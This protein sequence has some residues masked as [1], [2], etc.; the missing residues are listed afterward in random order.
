MQTLEAPVY[1]IAGITVLRDH[2]SDSDF[3][4][5][6]GP[7]HITRD[8]GEPVFSMLTYRNAVGGVN[9]NPVTRDQLGGAFLMFEVDCGLTQAQLTT[10]EGELEALVPP[11]TGPINLSPVLYTQGS[12]SIIA[13]DYQQTQAQAPGVAA[14]APPPVPPASVP[15]PGEMPSVPAPAAQAAVQAAQNAT[16]NN[17]VRGKIG[18]ATPSLMDDL[19][20]SFSLSL[21]PDAA[22]LL[23]DAYRNDLSPIGVMYELQFTALR[24]ALSVKAHGDKQKIYEHLK[25]AFHAGYTSGSASAGAPAARPATQAATPVRTATAPTTTPRPTTP[26]TT[27]TTTPTATPTSTP[28]AP[29]STTP[30]AT[31]ATPAATATVAPTTTPAATPGASA[32]A[33]TPATTPAATPTPTTTPAP[34]T[35]PTT[36]PRTTPTTTTPGTTTPAATTPA[37]QSGGTSVALSAD[38][39]VEVE[40][41]VQDATITIQIVREREDQTE[42]AMQAQAMD[43]IKQLI[44]QEFFTPQMST[45]ASAATGAASQFTGYSPSTAATSTG[46]AGGGRRVEVGF[47]LQYKHQEELDT[48]DVDFS[49]ASPETR[50]HAPNGFFS[51]LLTDVDMAT[52]IREI[53]LDDA[54]FKQIDV[55][56]S[57]T[58]DFA[59][60]DIESAVVELQHGGTLMQPEV[61]GEITFTPTNLAGAHFTASPDGGDYTVR[62]R[63]TYSFG[64]SPDIATLPNNS[65]RVTDWIVSPDRALVVHPADDASMRSV[66][67]EPGVIDWDV[68]EQVEATLSYNDPANNFTTSRTYLIA[69]GSPRQEWRVRLADP[70]VTDYTVQYRWHMRV[71]KKVIESPVQNSNLDHLYVPD[72]FVDRIPIV[73]SALVDSATVSRVDVEIDY[74]DDRNDLT[75]NKVVQVAGPAFVPLAMSI[76]L[77]DAD[78]RAYSY[79]ATIV[80]ISGAPEQQPPVDTDTSSLNVTAGG[81]LLALT[82]TLLEPLAAA[83]LDGLEVELRSAPPPGKPQQVVSVVFA[84]TDPTRASAQLLLPTDGADQ[85]EYRTTAYLATGGDPVVRAWVTNSGSNLVLQPAHLTQPG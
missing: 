64:D 4:Y 42:D 82:I 43:L 41:M 18:T 39:G 74:V 34:T 76:P 25:M 79:R 13:L 15:M 66:Y 47:Q 75:V 5:L 69:Q 12:V 24:P 9:V 60:Y 20:A 50:T 46:V 57:T 77:L 35:T 73:V 7:P 83:G 3:Y 22:V 71:T 10:I 44:T 40:K 16:Q 58:G 33:T 28:T 78:Q 52:H 55:T 8:S 26:A 72:P 21:S 48:F 31:S 11:G 63:T 32:P 27:P 17:F 85:F 67:V 49:V 61:A 62:H 80:N 30:A 29:A 53:N 45:A 1:N 51:A 56:V 84:P 54:F 14:A 2:Q 59:R 6:A 68:I 70:T 19:R 65:H 37:A 81:R 23:T 38:I 36:P